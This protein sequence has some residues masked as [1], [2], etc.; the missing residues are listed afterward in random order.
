MQTVLIACFLFDA[1]DPMEKNP[2][3]FLKLPHT[4]AN[5]HGGHGFAG[6]AREVLD[7]FRIHVPN[8]FLQVGRFHPFYRPQRPLGRVGV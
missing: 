2:K 6:I 7:K 4:L 3:T 5:I 1:G 8:L